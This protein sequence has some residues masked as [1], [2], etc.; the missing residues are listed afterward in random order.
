MKTVYYFSQTQ[1]NFQRR[2]NV[3]LDSNLKGSPVIFPSKVIDGC[4]FTEAKDFRDEEVIHQKNGFPDSYIVK[5]IP[6]H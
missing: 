1:W 3:N 4:T 5:V 6:N 2:T